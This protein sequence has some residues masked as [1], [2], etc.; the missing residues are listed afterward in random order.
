MWDEG[1]L[2]FAFYITD[3]KI[4]QEKQGNDM[5]EGDHVELWLDI[6]LEG[7]YNEAINSNDDIQFGFT[8]GDF[9]N[10][11]P[12]AHI[13]T[14]SSKAGH[15]SAIK[16]AAVKTDSGYI[17]EASISAD[18]FDTK[19][20]KGAKFGISIDP[21]DTDDTALPQKVLMSSSSDRVWGDPT[22]FGVLE[23][24]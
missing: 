3:D 14:P 7:D 15:K 10:L 24:Q 23:L 4:V 17:I 12:Q 18:L 21:S 9:N 22:T 8:A 6:D 16:I 5:W 13:W 11:T 2:Y 20:Q 19:L 1:S